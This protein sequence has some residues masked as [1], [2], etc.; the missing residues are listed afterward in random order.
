MTR[1]R[2]LEPRS[3]LF[4]AWAAIQFVLLLIVILI[5]WAI[6]DASLWWTLIFVAI[7]LLIAR[8]I[9]CGTFLSKE[10]VRVRHLWKTRTLGR[11]QV[12]LIEIRPDTAWGQK[13]QRIWL[14]TTTGER[15]D[16]RSE[17]LVESGH[18]LLR[19]V[20]ERDGVVLSASEF[21]HATELLHQ[22]HSGSGPKW[23][24]LPQ[25]D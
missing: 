23:R 17:G 24:S 13:S 7:A 11:D 18:G 14:R 19:L 5:V 12:V 4:L 25:M 1:W 22:W 20:G 9:R 2:R 10:K 6:G 8:N 15:V 16:T 3:L 21:H